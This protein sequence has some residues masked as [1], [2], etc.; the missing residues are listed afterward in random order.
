[1]YTNNV[2][3]ERPNRNQNG[4]ASAGNTHGSNVGLNPCEEPDR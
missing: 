2:G 4:L 1:M 3:W